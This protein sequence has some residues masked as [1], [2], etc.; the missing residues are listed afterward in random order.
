[1]ICL[2]APL[3]ANDRHW[4]TMVRCTREP[5][6]LS[7]HERALTTAST[8]PSSRANKATKPRRDGV[9]RA[10]LRGELEMALTHS[11]SR[12]TD[13]LA[14]SKHGRPCTCSGATFLLRVLGR[15]FPHE[16]DAEKNRYFTIPLTFR[17]SRIRLRALATCICGCV[18]LV[19]SALVRQSIVNYV[20]GCT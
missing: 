16:E 10:T 12:L 5:L 17:S 20:H 15:P 13:A 8:D 9:N 2:Q 3:T 11:G 14:A 1:M 18:C 6:C 19:Y 7:R 4:S